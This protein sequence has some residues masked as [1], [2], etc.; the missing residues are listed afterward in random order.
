MF[1]IWRVTKILYTVIKLTLIMD[2]KCDNAKISAK[3][4]IE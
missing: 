1:I 3:E 4:N 2:G